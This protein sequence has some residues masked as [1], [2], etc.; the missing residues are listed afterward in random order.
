MP[1]HDTATRD[2]SVALDLDSSSP[3]LSRLKFLLPTQHN[4][5]QKRHARHIADRPRSLNRVSIARVTATD[6]R[7]YF[8]P[9]VH[10][11]PLS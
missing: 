8:P 5:D 7:T 1:D 4:V 3:P 2:R 9:F 6:F 10:F 11:F